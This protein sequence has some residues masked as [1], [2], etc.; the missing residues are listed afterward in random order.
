MNAPRSRPVAWWVIP[1]VTLLASLALAAAFPL[2]DPDE[3]R[4]AEVAREMLAARDWLVPRLAG[5]PYLDKPPALYWLVALAV[6]VF[7]A[8]AWAA[9]LPS[10]LAAC[11]TLLVLG[12]R[13]A[14]LRDARFAVVTLTLLAAAPLFF[15]LS[16]YVIFDMLLALCVTAIWTGVA[17]ELERG[18]SKAGR[19]VMFAALGAGLLVKGPVMLAWAVG[20]SVAA[21]LAARSRAPLA[22]LGWIPGWVLALGVAGGWFVLAAQRH[23]E[24]PHYAFLEESLE[25][26]ATGHFHRRQAWWFV[27]AVLAGGAL[28]WSLATP[29]WR[30]GP[31]RPAERVALGYVLFAAVF[32]TLSQSKLVTYLVPA[33]PPLAWLAARAWTAA[34]ARPR[35]ITTAAVAFTIALVTAALTLGRPWLAAASGQPLARAIARTAPGAPVVFDHCWSPAVDFT[36]GRPSVIVSP[37]GAE[38]TSN[39]QRRYRTRLLAADAWTLHDSLTPPRDSMRVLVRPRGAPWSGTTPFFRDARFIAGIDR[40]IV[41]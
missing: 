13:A 32:F 29:W 20:G 7:G 2:L 10:A 25:R 38:T 41:R 26:V 24:Y 1:V 22:W 4:N 16:A 8:H 34:G 31:Q 12:G 6:R 17:M 35:V 11:V 5:M 33:L 37:D 3:G 23:P 9:R 15:V 27:P 30:I 18:R 36:L 14:R 40:A 19:W 39:Y 28:P 21:A